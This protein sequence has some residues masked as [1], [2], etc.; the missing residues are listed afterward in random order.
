VVEAGYEWIELGP[1]GYLPTDPA[2]LGAELSARGLRATCGFISGALHE[3]GAWPDLERQAREAGSL[4][5]AL[6]IPN[7]MLMSSAFHDPQTGEAF[8]PRRLTGV[9][10]A[11]FVETTQRVAALLRDEYGVRLLFHPHAGMYVET[12]EEIAALL[13]ETDPALVSLCFDTGQHLF[14]GG[15]PVAFMRE[16]HARIPYLHL[17]SVDGA[18]LERVRAEDI[19]INAAVD[20]GI[21]CEPSE[22]VIDFAAFFAVLREVDFSGFGIVEQDMFPAPFDKPL[23][24]ARRSLAYYREVWARVGR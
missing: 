3:P 17:K 11:R 14:A 13:A 22:G 20:L 16:Y 21:F 1:I 2:T 6:G 9:T 15:D 7:M 8:G 23:P 4:L 10:W 24:I 12:E 5:A 18:V 19:P